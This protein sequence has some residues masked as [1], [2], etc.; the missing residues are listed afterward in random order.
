MHRHPRR[1]HG[2]WSKFE[3][4]LELVQ[5][6]VAAGVDAE[7]LDRQL[8][9][10]DVAPDLELEDVPQDHGGQ[11]EE[12]LR[13]GEDQRPQRGDVDLQGVAG[14]AMSSLDRVMPTL[15]F[16]SSSCVTQE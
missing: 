6:C 8:E 3:A 2:A 7:V 16:A 9:V 13:D 11:E 10:G 5:H 12:L 4:L 14:D 15:P 1:L